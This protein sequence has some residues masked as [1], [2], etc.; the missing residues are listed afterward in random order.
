MEL[1]EQQE[2][3]DLL[4]SRRDLMISLASAINVVKGTVDQ[5]MKKD[6]GFGKELESRIVK[7][8]IS[9]SSNINKTLAYELSQLE[10]N[11]QENWLVL[12]A[13]FLAYIK[14]NNDNEDHYR[15]IS[16]FNLNEKERVIIV[17][18]NGI[19]HD[20][21]FNHEHTHVNILDRNQ[22]SFKCF[23]QE[24]R[25]M[26]QPG[27]WDNFMKACQTYVEHFEEK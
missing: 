9:V 2:R 1:K 24:L 11:E 4:K 18:P 27:V 21:Y 15:D 23:M 25:E 8:L 10:Y 17:D 5:I 22:D 3:I 12:R 14:L 19:L 26:M 20:Y 13:A 6:Q 7:P 16:L